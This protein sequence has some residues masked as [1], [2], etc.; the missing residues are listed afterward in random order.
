MWHF[1]LEKTCSEEEL[2]NLN[3]QVSEIQSFVDELSASKSL[4]ETHMSE[5]ELQRDQAQQKL[6]ELESSSIKLNSDLEVINYFH[7]FTIMVHKIAY[8]KIQKHQKDLKT[9]SV[10]PTF[11]TSRFNYFKTV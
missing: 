9:S 2:S 4:L 8:C 10:I 11:R 1:F 5:L 3:V 6:S 7:H